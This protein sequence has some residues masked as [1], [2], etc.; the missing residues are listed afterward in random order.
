MISAGNRA[1]QANPRFSY[2]QVVQAAALMQ[3]SR[4]GE[5]QAVARRVLEIEPSF[6]VN[7]FVRAHTGRAEIRVRNGLPAG[8]RRIRTLSPGWQVGTGT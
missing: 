6:T 7:E 2:P 8:G 3:A 5:A 4:T 1:A